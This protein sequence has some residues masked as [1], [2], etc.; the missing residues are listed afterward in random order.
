MTASSP[1]RRFR[2]V[3]H[4]APVSV[5]DERWQPVPPDQSILWF[6]PRQHVHLGARFDLEHTG[7]LAAA[8]HGVD[9]W[10]FLADIPYGE[11]SLQ[12]SGYQIQRR[13][14]Q[15]S[16]PRPRMSTFISP[17]ASISSLSH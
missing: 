8:Q 7:A 16:M 11:W 17:S 13:R 9:R 2:W 12:L 5:Q 4:A 14:I 15:D 6:E 3:H 10:I 1:C